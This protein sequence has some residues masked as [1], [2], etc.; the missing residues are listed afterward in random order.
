MAKAHLS[1]SLDKEIKELLVQYAKENH[2][3]MSQAVTAWVLAEKRKAA[4]ERTK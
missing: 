4:A 2:M 3:T 1:L